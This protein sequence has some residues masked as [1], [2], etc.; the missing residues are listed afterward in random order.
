MIAAMLVGW[1]LACWP[2]AGSAQATPMSTGTVWAGGSAYVTMALVAPAD[3]CQLTASS[4]GRTVSLSTITPTEMHIAWV[5][6][7]PARA[8]SATW[9]VSAICGSSQIGVVLTVRG[10]RHHPTL[11]LARRLQVFQFGGEFPNPVQLQL[12]LLPALARTWW[13]LTSSSILS[14]FHKG[15]A[16]GECTDYVVARRP[17]VVARVDVWAYVRELLAHTGSLGVNWAAKDWGVNAQQAGLST[18]N[19]PQAGAVIVFQP[20]SYGA[21][22]QGHVALVSAVAVDGSFTISEMH[23]P[24]VARVTTRHFGARTARAMALDPGVTFIY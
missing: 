19:R 21:L 1:V 8:R 16:A 18:G 14:A 12:G 9:Q 11:T 23:A 15:S 10:R 13:A 2:G 20:G 17:D 4:G 24:A 22:S 3:Q 6:Q 5:W 7:V